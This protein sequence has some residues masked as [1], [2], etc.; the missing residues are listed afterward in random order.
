MELENMYFIL[1]RVMGL[2][3]GILTIAFGLELC[4]QL[5][6]NAWGGIIIILGS[7]ITLYHL[8]FINKNNTIPL[9]VL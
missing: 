7:F 5:S 3:A 9:E 6:V 2:G 1:E 8:T 4:Y